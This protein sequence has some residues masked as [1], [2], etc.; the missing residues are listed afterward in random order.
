MDI[1]QIEDKGTRLTAQN[2][3]KFAQFHHVIIELNTYWQNLNEYPKKEGT[4]V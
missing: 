2:F 4:H 3:F 1:P